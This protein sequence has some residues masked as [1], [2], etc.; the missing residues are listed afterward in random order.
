MH[1]SL[2]TVLLFTD[3]HAA[4]ARDFLLY[5]S[6]QQRFL[7]LVGCTGD[8]PRVLRG[9]SWNNNPEN[10]R[11]SNRNRNNPDNR[12]NNI[13]FRVLC[14]SHI[15]QHHQL[16]TGPAHYGQPGA[17]VVCGMALAPPAGSVDLKR[18]GM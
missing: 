15:P 4:A 16:P 5:C 18:S 17:A 2:T 11:S 1:W 8:D 13:G 10:A 12:N 9:G 14:S 6:C 3:R 7:L